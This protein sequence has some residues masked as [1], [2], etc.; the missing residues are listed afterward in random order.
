VQGGEDQ[1]EI[2]FCLGLHA[3]DLMVGRR[4]SA[5]RAAH[6]ELCSLLRLFRASIACCSVRDSRL[7][8]AGIARCSVRD[9]RLFRASIA[10]CSVRDSRCF[11][12]VSPVAGVRDRLAMHQ[13]ARAQIPQE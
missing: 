6:R 9:S 11:G 1:A 8:R 2:D 12:P 3:L 5:A 7:F 13:G 10:C 4:S